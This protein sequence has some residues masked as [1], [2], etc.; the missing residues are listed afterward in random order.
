MPRGLN[1][2]WIDLNLLCRFAGGDRE[3]H[4]DAQE[5]QQRAA[6]NGARGD[7]QEHVPA[8]QKDDQ[9]TDRVAHRTQVHEERR[10]Q[11][12]HVQLHGVVRLYL[13]L[14]ACAL[15]AQ[16]SCTWRNKVHLHSEE[17]TCVLGM[18]CI[19]T[20]TE[21]SCTL[22]NSDA[23][24]GENFLFRTKFSFFNISPF[25]FY[26]LKLPNQPSPFSAWWVSGEDLALARW[27]IKTLH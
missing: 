23:V 19:C 14:S 10:W 21:C 18:Q 12:Q 16:C 9:R 8:V 1:A 4:E 27:P 22:D 25:V 24:W 5:D 3:D 20:W 26:F 11:H 15:R 17:T 2:C 13:E 7:P 6:A